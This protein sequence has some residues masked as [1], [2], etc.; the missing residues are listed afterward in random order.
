MTEGIRVT[1]NNFIYAPWYRRLPA[2]VID[3]LMIDLVV[4]LFIPGS[5][6]IVN[7]LLGGNYLEGLYFLGS[8]DGMWFLILPALYFVL[9]W[10][11]M[12]RTVGMILLKIRI[13]DYHGKRIGWIKTLLRL[14]ALLIAV[15]P[16]G[17]GCLPIIFDK[18]K[19]G[20]QDKLTKTQVI[21]K[22]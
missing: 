14:F 7:L 10:G 15:L 22:R 9:I 18:K 2:F 12:S 8:S 19:Q 4:L 17:I 21:I 20:L 1:T 5:F 3:K 11:I 6:K 13:A 16:L